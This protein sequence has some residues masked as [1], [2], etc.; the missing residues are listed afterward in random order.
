[1]ADITEL[2][3]MVRLGIVQ[4]VNPDKMTARVRFDD[5][6]GII[7]GELHIIRHPV[8]VVPGTKDKAG[9]KTASTQ[10]EFDTNNELTKKSHSHAAYI[11]EWV[12]NIND[13]V[14]CIMQPD[15]GGDGYIIG[16]V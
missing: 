13:M 8:N 6:G 9:D 11:T 3:N 14:L 10:L 4:N 15:G 1:M 16:E 7:S 5:K 12:P 2:K